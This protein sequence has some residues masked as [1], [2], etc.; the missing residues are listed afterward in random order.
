MSIYPS[1][2][3]ASDT[4]PITNLPKENQNMIIEFL[5]QSA[6]L[7]LTVVSKSLRDSIKEFYNHLSWTYQTSPY[8]NR[9][10][11]P[12]DNLSSSWLMREFVGKTAAK[13]STWMRSLG[14]RVPRSIQ[15]SDMELRIQQGIEAESRRLQALLN[16]PSSRQAMAQIRT[17]PPEVY[18]RRDQLLLE[19]EAKEKRK[20]RAE[21]P[22]EL[23]AGS[24]NKKFRRL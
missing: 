24:G 11:F 5:P 17:A 4:N 3:K 8:L 7:S 21:N 2:F 20:E 22:P 1:N 23:I 14:I 9:F 6:H 16:T 18:A 19:I 10:K 13:A 12:L 15:V